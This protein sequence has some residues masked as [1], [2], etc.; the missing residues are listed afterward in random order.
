MIAVQEEEWGVV[1]KGVV[2]EGVGG[3]KWGRVGVS[4]IRGGGRESSWRWLDRYVRARCNRR[5]GRR[6]GAGERGRRHRG[7]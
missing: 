2:E 3:C 7:R 4:G 1:A 5:G 6:R